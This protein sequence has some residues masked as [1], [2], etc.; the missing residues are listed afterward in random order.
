MEGKLI[1][2]SCSD[3]LKRIRHK[4]NNNN[5]SKHSRWGWQDRLYTKVLIPGIHLLKG[6]SRLHTPAGALKDPIQM[7][8]RINVLKRSTLIIESGVI[9]ADTKAGWFLRDPGQPRKLIFYLLID[10]GSVLLC[11]CP[12]L[13]CLDLRSLRSLPVPP[14]RFTG[15][16]YY[17]V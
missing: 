15:E 5:N 2:L 13:A 11:A 1:P 3:S 4:H 9:E 16:S 6:W 8:T 17:S 12:W 14:A 10:Q 7:Q